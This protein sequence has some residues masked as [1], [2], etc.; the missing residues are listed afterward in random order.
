[1]TVKEN[2]V[3]WGTPLVCLR[4]TH[5][6]PGSFITHASGASHRGNPNGF[7]MTRLD[8]QN[9]LGIVGGGF[10][11]QLWY[12]VK[13]TKPG[14]QQAL[15]TLG[16]Y[17]PIDTLYPDRETLA[18][19]IDAAVRGE[20]EGSGTHYAWSH[21]ATESLGDDEAIRAK[22]LEKLMP[23]L[24]ATQFK[25]ELLGFRRRHLLFFGM[26]D[27]TGQT[28]YQTIAPVPIN[29]SP[30]DGLGRLSARYRNHFTPE[31]MEQW[32]A[33]GDRKAP[34]PT[35][36]RNNVGRVMPLLYKGPAWVVRFLLDDQDPMGTNRMW[37][38]D[39][40]EFISSDWCQRHNWS[41]YNRGI[42]YQAREFD[43]PTWLT[44][45]LA[46]RQMKYKV[47]KPKHPITH[48]QVKDLAVA[49]PVPPIVAILREAFFQERFLG[50][51]DMAEV[52][53]YLIDPLRFRIQLTTERDWSLAVP[54]KPKV[55]HMIP[56]GTTLWARIV[57][58]GSL[59]YEYGPLNSPEDTKQKRGVREMKFHSMN[60]GFDIY[61]SSYFSRALA[62]AQTM[63][64][65]IRY[66]EA[67]GMIGK[68]NI[69]EYNL[70]I[71]P[72]LA[73]EA[74]TSVV[75]YWAEKVVG[76]P[77]AP[78]PI[79]AGVDEEELNDVWN[80]EDEDEEEEEEQ[81]EEQEFGLEVREL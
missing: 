18:A 45:G 70:A 7:A 51:Y 75:D 76:A 72:E 38:T 61:A 59:Y 30:Y 48:F 46:K 20:D 52:G 41:T 79:E 66:L 43:I 17:A 1:M 55:L 58:G 25:V 10:R 64:S 67:G 77:P 78:A 47:F 2:T 15:V 24:D 36:W 37:V 74:W 31:V 53:G 32:K 16:E 3:N 71:E 42:D 6:G 63:W 54:H 44:V 56:K 33:S 13:E 5:G 4:D 19:K 80:R 68:L 62:V 29:D 73:P 27:W 21:V 12:P 9:E 60:H 50:K 14:Y 49:K 57:A 69:Y 26:G 81:E 39:Q 40:A 28:I 22:F 65:G 11:R 23:Q 8:T 34:W 35:A